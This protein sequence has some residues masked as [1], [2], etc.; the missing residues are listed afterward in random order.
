MVHKWQKIAKNGHKMAKLAKDVKNYKFAYFFPNF[1]Y[2]FLK[3]CVVTSFV[4]F[5]APIPET[6]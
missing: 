5:V 2:I 4:A 1:P 6:R 3:K